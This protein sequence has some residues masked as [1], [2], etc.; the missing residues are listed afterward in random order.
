VLDIYPASELPIPGITA[1]LLARRIAV[2]GGQKVRY[3]SSFPEA[4]T[5]AASATQSGDMV[6][7]LG[8]G[9]VWQLGPR[10][11]EELKSYA[12]ANRR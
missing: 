9:S 6:L 7:T 10:I 4:A 12:S 2:S 3:V 11:L 5:L 1:E 8:A